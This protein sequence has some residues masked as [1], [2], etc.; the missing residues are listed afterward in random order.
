[1][2]NTLVVLL[3]AVVFIGL[4][5]L[6]ACSRTPSRSRQKQEPDMR[7]I[8]ERYGK[9]I[10]QASLEFRTSTT[11]LREDAG[12]KLVPILKAKTPQK[13]VEH[14]LGMP[15]GE[16]NLTNGKEWSYV[17]G[18]SKSI[19]VVFDSNDEVKAVQCIPSQ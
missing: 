16:R 19:F 1:M 3:I 12:A 7:S 4:T 13:E 9:E 6:Y 5:V 2:K 8:E 17:T 10:S 18:Y 15:D 14:L 11:R